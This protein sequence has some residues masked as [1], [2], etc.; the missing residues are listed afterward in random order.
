MTAISVLSGSRGGEASAQVIQLLHEALY[1]FQ[2]SADGCNIL[3]A[4]P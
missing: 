3:A 4:A 1:R 2:I